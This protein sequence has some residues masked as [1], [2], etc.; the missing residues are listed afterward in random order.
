MPATAAAILEA[1]GDQRGRC[2]SVGASA[3][4]YRTWLE[5]D[6]GRF[7]V[8]VGTRPA[9][10]APVQDLGLIVVS[11]ESHPA[12]REDRAPYYHVRDVALARTRLEHGC[13]RA[14]GAVPVVGGRCA[15]VA[16]VALHAALAAG[17][18]GARRAGGTRI[19]TGPRATGDAPGVHLLAV[20]WVRHRAGLSRM[21]APGRVRGVRW[22]APIGGRRRS[23][24]RVRGARPVRALWRCGLRDPPW[25]SGA[26]RRVGGDASPPVPVRRVT[27]RAPA[28]LPK[29]T[30][31]LVGGPEYVR[32]LG[33]GGLDLVGDP[34]RGP[35]GAATRSG[36]AGTRARDLDGGG[37]DGRGP[38]AARSC[39]RTHRATRR[40]RHWCAATRTGS[41]S[42]S[43]AGASAAGFPVGSA[44]F[45]IAG[46]RRSSRR[47]SRP[48]IPSRCSSRR[49]RG[50]RYACSRSSPVAS[51]EFGRTIR[52]LAAA[53]HRGAGRGRTAPVRAEPWSSR[54]DHRRSASWA[55]P[56]CASPRSP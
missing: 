51:R 45:R 6:G 20:A 31:I 10:F 17:G 33:P 44:V 49:S 23:M 8:V 42:T 2:S 21:R 37:R 14:L 55:T 35:G 25:R 48:S 54:R 52:D 36:V 9:V 26:R 18:G 38:R 22:R 53:R 16:E 11:R 19:A 1:F 24:R 13:V 15:R 29:A 30:E 39:R 43:G 28:R 27:A 56:C 4:R 32:D 47:S 3:P 50:R 12:H 40:S 34:R 41:I 46:D 7:D 5:I